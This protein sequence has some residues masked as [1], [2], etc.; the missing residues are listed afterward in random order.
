MTRIG[1][2]PAKLGMQA[3]QP[4]KLGLATI[5]YIPSLEGYFRDSLAIL[6]L[7]LESLHKNTSEAFDLLVFD[8]GSCIEIQDELLQLQHQG[9][10]QWLHLSSVNLGKTGAQNWIFSAMP[11]EWIGYTD[12]DVLFRKRWLES[13][14]DIIDHF[15]EAG[16]VGAQPCYFDVLKGKGKAHQE[17][18]PG[19]DYKILDYIPD[20][21]VTDEYC[22]GI[23]AAPE[24]AAKY[25]AM[26]LQ[27]VQNRKDDFSAVI[28]ASHMQFLIPAQLAK[29]ILP[30]PYR[31]GLS[32]EEDRQLDLR[33]DQHGRLHLST[34][35]PFVVHMGNVLDDWVI[36]LAGEAGISLGTGQPTKRNTQTL[37]TGRTYGLGWLAKHAGTRRW[38]VRLYNKL[39]QV[40]S[41][42]P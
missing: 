34:L 2:N 1:Q 18:N 32:Q 16:M 11:N 5:T 42:R 8:N 41:D 17:L 28:G 14:R 37:S 22:R 23:N 29:S 38:L 10:I 9:D 15:P 19:A 33:I 31:L 36:S 7:M 35:E 27:V 3:Y 20:A 21:M 4:K 39:F 26:Q 6:K 25:R 30:L 40:L 13:S 12:S 24:Q